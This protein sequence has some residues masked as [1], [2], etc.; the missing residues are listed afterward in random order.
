MDDFLARVAGILEVPEVRPDTDFRRAFQWD[1]L[2]AFALV[3]MIRQR[4]GR[5]VALADIGA[6]S[7]VADLARL[8]GVEDR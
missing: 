7:T 5:T 4:Y 3:V 2:T 6:A 1:S 8:A